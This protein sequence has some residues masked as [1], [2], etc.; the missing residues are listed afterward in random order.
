MS[1][2]TTEP[3]SLQDYD[4]NNNNT[5]TSFIKDEIQKYTSVIND[6]SEK[7]L[8]TY[9]NE[10]T[11]V[12]T[13]SILEKNN[14]LLQL[15]V[16]NTTQVLDDFTSKQI[17]NITTLYS[18]LLVST[19]HI[20]KDVKQTIHHENKM[21]I[22]T[23]L[24]TIHETLNNHICNHI[25]NINNRIVEEHL[26]NSQRLTE[27]ITQT[28][29]DVPHNTSQSIIDN[30]NDILCTVVSNIVKECN[31]Q[32]FLLI[33]TLMEN[34]TSI[35]SSNVDEKAK[36]IEI[37]NCHNFD[38]ITSHIINACDNS[39]NNTT[40]LSEK[41]KELILDLIFRTKNEYSTKSIINAKNT[42]I[43]QLEHRLLTKRRKIHEL[44]NIDKSLQQFIRYVCHE[45]R[46]PFNSICMAIEL[47]DNNE[48]V[49]ISEEGK[50]IVKMLIKSTQSMKI[51]MDDTLDYSKMRNGKFS[52]LNEPNN[53]SSVITESIQTMNVYAS[54]YNIKLSSE[55]SPQCPKIALFDYGRI[56]QVLNNLISNALKFS[57]KDGTGDVRVMIDV[58]DEDK[59]CR[60]NNSIEKQHDNINIPNVIWK[61][62]YDDNNSN[63]NNVSVKNSSCEILCI[64]GYSM[65]VN[66]TSCLPNKKQIDVIEKGSCIYSFMDTTDTPPTT[67]LPTDTHNT[68]LQ[69]KTIVISVS[70]NGCGI[71]SD[72]ICG[73]YNDFYQ[74]SS[75]LKTL[76][77]G[78]G[79]GLSICRGIIESHGG[80]IGIEYNPTTSQG[81]K[82][83]C[84][85]RLPILFPKKTVAKI[86]NSQHVNH[87]KYPLQKNH[88]HQHHNKH[89]TIHKSGSDCKT[90]SC[91]ADIELQTQPTIRILIVDDV[92]T[93][94]KLLKM[95]I[96]MYVNNYNKTCDCKD[97][98]SIEIVCVS[99]GCHAVSAICGISYEKVLDKKNMYY[100]TTTTLPP[101]LNPRIR[102]NSDNRKCVDNTIFA[103]C[104]S[105]ITQHISNYDIITMDA[106][107]PNINGYIATQM[108][109]DAG[110]TGY[111]IGCTGNVIQED[112]NVF[113]DSGV[114]KVFSKPIN[115][116]QLLKYTIFNKD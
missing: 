59:T 40:Q 56:M 49:T 54:E 23:T 60:V 6:I 33:D 50:D 25:S 74:T 46:T 4:N 55:I 39:I 14:K 5:N 81:T 62:N 66:I 106:H 108:I 34:F 78:T 52:I 63:N 64:E 17:N 69:F 112:V 29:H 12:I 100:T 1:E 116:E 45:M 110:F 96:E 43:V 18:E 2:E 85:L 71:E 93:N 15:L 103:D 16:N 70:D 90:D 115:V 8:D 68:I 97:K 32:T 107:M 89:R 113:I 19:T 87:P 22:D 73:L 38:I 83:Y 36:H 109:R 30:A 75:G 13:T 79:L 72:D 31:E 27:S 11:E 41:T 80:R 92:E 28:M 37:I 47:L 114:D 7:T 53:I 91:T 99:D 104:E 82:M 42:I 84:V 65:C 88:H 86:S 95:S 21:C 111:V 67:I 105:E 76:E 3:I 98:R 26:L 35:V 44:E 94:R 61:H 20:F 102:L 58:L 77:K 9:S 48:R 24:L 10:L 57:P 51:I 101:N